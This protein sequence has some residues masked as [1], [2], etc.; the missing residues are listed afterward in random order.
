MTKKSL[1]LNKYGVICG[2]GQVPLK[3]VHILKNQGFSVHI[4]KLAGEANADYSSFSFVE[5]QIGQLEK[6]SEYFV[7]EKCTDIIFSGKIHQSSIAHINPDKTLTSILAGSKLAGDNYI[8]EAIGAYFKG[9]GFDVISEDQ[10]LPRESL[11]QNY[12]SSKIAEGR[13]KEDIDIG[14]EF[15]SQISRFDVGQSLII[16]SGRVLALEAAEGTD[17]MIKR[18]SAL[19]DPDSSPAIFMKMAKIGQSLMHDLPV[20]G[21]NTIEFL[22]RSNIK[23]V[24]LQAEKCKL[25]EPLVQ[26]EAAML[27]ADI[28]LYAVNYE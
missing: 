12:R 27:R 4:V 25:A 21:L 19:I 1:S 28:S 6:I 9:Q 22:T 20:F 10:V 18:A 23:I 16:Q 13:I 15:L 11:S 3:I 26:I 2:A 5:I 17:E 14:I 24:C 8:L 7:E